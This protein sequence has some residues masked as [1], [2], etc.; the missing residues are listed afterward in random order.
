M[1]LVNDGIVGKRD[2][3]TDDHKRKLIVLVRGLMTMIVIKI[4][5]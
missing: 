3:E 4:R 1:H 2:T 5:Y